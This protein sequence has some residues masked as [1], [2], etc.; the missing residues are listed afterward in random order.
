M[1]TDVADLEQL[2][3][4]YESGRVLVGP[5]L[6]L[7]INASYCYFHLAGNGSKVY[8]SIGLGFIE[9][10]THAQKQRAE[11]I[12][13]LKL[14]FAEVTLFDD[15]TEM[16]RAVH[17]QWATEETTRVLAAAERATKAESSPG[18]RTTYHKP[19]NEVGDA[20]P[21]NSDKS[22]RLRAGEFPEHHQSAPLADQ[23]GRDGRFI[24][25]EH[26]SIAP[27]QGGQLAAEPAT[28]SEGTKKA[29]QENPKSRSHEND[30]ASENC[31]HQLA[32]ALFDDS[33]DEPN[34]AVEATAFMT[35]LQG[36]T[37]RS[38]NE[39]SAKTAYRPNEIGGGQSKDHNGAIGNRVRL[40]FANAAARDEVGSMGL[41]PAAT[42]PLLANECGEAPGKQKCRDLGLTH[43]DI[44]SAILKLAS[45]AQP[46]ISTSPAVEPSRKL[47][48]SPEI[49]P[50]DSVESGSESV[51]VVLVRPIRGWSTVLRRSAMVPATVFLCTFA[52]QGTREK[53]AVDNALMV[54][55]SNV[56]S[57]SAAAVPLPVSQPAYASGSAQKTDA[58]VGKIHTPAASSNVNLS[59]AEKIA[60]LVNR[61]MESLKRGD[62]EAARLSLQRAAEAIP[63]PAALPAQI[64]PSKPTIPEAA[65]LRRPQD[66]Y[67]SPINSLAGASRETQAASVE[68]RV[69]SSSA[70]KIPAQE[71]SIIRHLDPNEMA[72]LLR[73]G[74]DFLKSGDVASARVTLRRAAEAGNAEAALALGSAY[75]PS[76][77]RQLGATTIAADIVQAREW[78]EKASRFGSAAAAQRLATLALPAP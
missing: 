2:L 32:G 8:E 60:K 23:A 20:H 50:I 35:E 48:E 41:P 15:Y 66:R 39:E 36:V 61:G 17:A 63:N 31:F 58:A 67:S 11:I 75:D 19:I 7:Q 46:A 16:A 57:K 51:P 3:A 33:P 13:K 18:P 24:S 77:L 45:P 43:D 27:N 59:E 34:R 14:R 4:Q 22:E 25:E 78:Y 69:E 6:N 73:R 5:L 56:P 30:S 1:L 21:S 68:A 62:L 42:L 29:G 26:S 37:W 49:L 71:D 47:P 10:E 65:K 9:N 40:P 76:V 28:A 54:A 53:Q 70:Q 74:M 55:V 72:V 38:L 64:Q 44:A 52:P 12:K